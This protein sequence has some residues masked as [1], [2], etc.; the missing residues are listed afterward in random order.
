MY[1][2]VAVDYFSKWAEAVALKKAKKENIVFLC[3][4]ISSIDMMHLDILSQ[5][6][7]D[8]LLTSSLAYVRSLSLP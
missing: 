4:Q 8:R 7:A 1:V 2:L 5:T 6:M 3:G